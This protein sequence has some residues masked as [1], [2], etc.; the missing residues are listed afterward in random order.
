MRPRAKLRSAAPLVPTGALLA[1]A[2][3]VG[4]SGRD[5]STVEHPTAAAQADTTALPSALGGSAL[6]SVSFESGSAAAAGNVHAL[7]SVAPQLTLARA[8]AA[9][10][11]TS[12]ASVDTTP[13]EN[14]AR[15]GSNGT[16]QGLVVEEARTNYFLNSRSPGSVCASSHVDR[17]ILCSVPVGY[18]EAQPGTTITAGYAPGPDGSPTGSRVRIAPNQVSSLAGFL[19]GSSDAP[20]APGDLLVYSEWLRA[21]ADATAGSIVQWGVCDNAYHSR[22]ALPA[23]TTQWTRSVLTPLAR[24]ANGQSLAVAAAFQDWGFCGDV[25]VGVPMKAPVDQ[26]VDLIQAEKGAFA[27]E[28]IVTGAGPATRAGDHLQIVDGAGAVANG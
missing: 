28:P 26:V 10:V 23:V 21:S 4:C 2:V 9:T 12:A 6:W 25:G 24:D 5:T 18:I 8:S 20:I 11:Q 27:T 3:V 14:D 19:H 7:T 22:W 17:G 15:I 16:A 13:G 1:A